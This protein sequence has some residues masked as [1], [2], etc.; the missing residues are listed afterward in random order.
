[1]SVNELSAKQMHFEWLDLDEM[2]EAELSYP[3]EWTPVTGEKTFKA[4]VGEIEMYRSGTASE[5]V[6]GCWRTARQQGAFGHIIWNIFNLAGLKDHAIRQGVLG[7][8]KE[9]NL[10]YAQQL[11][12]IAEQIIAM[13][14]LEYAFSDV[15]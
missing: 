9:P 6:K 15:N 3:P 8:T 7:R 4:M 11:K 1:M 5:N 10:E 14:G 12:D 2:E 13:H